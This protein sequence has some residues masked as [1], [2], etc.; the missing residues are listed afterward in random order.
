M[1][2]RVDMTI[3]SSESTE[4]SGG[5]NSNI[6]L[7][8]VISRINALEQNAV[9]F[10][11]IYVQLSGK[12]DPKSLWPKNQWLEVTNEYA[13]LFFRAEGGESAK[14]GDE[15]DNGLPKLTIKQT[16]TDVN[17]GNIGCW[18]CEDKVSQNTCTKKMYLGHD[19]HTSST[20]ITSRDWMEVCMSGDEVRPKN[21]AVRI[22]Q[23][24]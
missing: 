9:P 2:I 19:T 20:P 15:Q 16:N 23:R 6:N 17:L 12:P 4:S 8:N 10:G 13:G 7:L 22:W 11:F 18:N 1:G 21:Q 3:T 5:F 24:Y 14:F